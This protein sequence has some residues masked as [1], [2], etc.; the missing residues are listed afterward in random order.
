M[1]AMFDFA[2]HEIRARMAKR[3]QRQAFLA[4][5]GCDLAI[6]EAVKIGQTVFQIDAFGDVTVD[7]HFH[8]A[9]GN[10][11]GDETMRLHRRQAKALGNGR[12][13]HAGDEM[14]PGGAKRQRIVC[15]CH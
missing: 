11:L 9:V 4:N 15:I 10:G 5:I 13:S 6:I 12:L 3:H 2:A 14:K 1:I 7:G 8:R